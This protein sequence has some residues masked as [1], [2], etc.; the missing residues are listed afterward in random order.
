MEEGNIMRIFRFTF[1]ISSL[2]K[3]FKYA[4]IIKIDTTTNTT[5]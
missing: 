5:N 1:Y 3:N 2:F 4:L